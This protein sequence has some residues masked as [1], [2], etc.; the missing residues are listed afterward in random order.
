MPFKFSREKSPVES[1]FIEVVYL[2]P[3][4]LKD[5]LQQKLFAQK[6][7]RIYRTPAVNPFHA[8]DLFWY[9][10]KTSEYQRVSDVFWGYQKRSVAPNGLRNVD[11]NLQKNQPY[12]EYLQLN[13]FVVNSVIQKICRFVKFA[14]MRWLC[15]RSIGEI[16]LGSVVQKRAPSLFFLNNFF[17]ERSFVTS[18]FYPKTTFQPHLYG[19]CCN[20]YLV[21]IMNT[22]ILI[23]YKF[24]FKKWRTRECFVI[25]L[26]ASLL[27]SRRAFPYYIFPLNTAFL[28]LAIGV[29]K[30]GRR[31]GQKQPSRGVLTKRCSENMQQI[32]RRTPMSKCD[33]NKV[34][35]Q[36]YWKHI[37][38]S[39]PL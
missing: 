1:S 4:S 39:V 34:S 14:F 5:A 31:N 21:V 15:F 16:D 29:K 10:L 13:G 30:K 2:G 19:C 12:L 37:G 22:E 35:K 33:F 27:L 6:F 38:M 9:P 3:N 7:S 25:K 20:K 24:L 36:H 11:T 23:F 26:S 32:Y 17:R 18:S 8:T 28:K